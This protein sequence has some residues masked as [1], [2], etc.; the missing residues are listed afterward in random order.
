MNDVPCI[1]IFW[2]VMR[3]DRPQLF[4]CLRP[5]P[6]GEDYGDFKT[7][8]TAHYDLW[9]RIKRKLNISGE[10]EDWPRGRVVYD[11]PGKRFTAYIDRQLAGDTYR[12]AILHAFH[13]PIERTRFAFDAH[14][15]RAKFKVT[16][17]CPLCPPIAF[18]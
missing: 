6:E 16:G 5:W 11:L 14:Y 4:A 17:T 18:R 3:G 10:Y 2:F 13:L 7:E 1:G 12:T 8:P 9:P 15:G